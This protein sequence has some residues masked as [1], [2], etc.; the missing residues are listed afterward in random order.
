VENGP[1]G[2]HRSSASAR[3][4]DGQ[5]L[6]RRI[7]EYLGRSYS[8]G[9]RDRRALIVSVAGGTVV[10]HYYGGSTATVTADVRSVTKSVVGTL[11]GVAL[12]QGRLRSVDQ[13]LGE[14]CPSVGPTCRPGSLP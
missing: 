12:T 7:E 13:T 5:V 9:I 11:V 2:D 10:E 1:I 8:L 6:G 14:F 4:L 3:S